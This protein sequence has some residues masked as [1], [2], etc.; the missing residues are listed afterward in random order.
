MRHDFETWWWCLWYSEK[1][2]WFLHGWLYMSF[3]WC[4]WRVHDLYMMF[5]AAPWVSIICTWTLNES[6]RR[7]FVLHVL[8]W[9]P[10]ISWLAHDLFVFHIV[11]VHELEM[12]FP[13]PPAW[14]KTCFC[15]FA[16]W[17]F[18]A[19]FYKAGLYQVAGTHHVHHSLAAVRWMPTVWMQHYQ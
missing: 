17:Q 13:D 9:S 16:F 5:I 8:K 6:T 4:S 14:T 3:I 7:S 1:Y 11:S 12:I 2:E 10:M 15:D 18:G 19:A